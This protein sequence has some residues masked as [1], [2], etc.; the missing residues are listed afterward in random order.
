[1]A[2]ITLEQAEARLAEYMAAEAKVLTKQ[3]YRLEGRELTLADL[4]VIQAGITTWNNRVQQLSAAT[5]GRT[6]GR[7]IVPA[8]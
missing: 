5:S 6:R 3:S 4:D 8:G 1:M 2:G 7:T